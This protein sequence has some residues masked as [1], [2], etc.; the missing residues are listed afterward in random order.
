LILKNFHAPCPA[1]DTARN[2][3]S[4][5]NGGKW[6]ARRRQV[7]VLLTLSSH[8]PRRRGF[9]HKAKSAGFRRPIPLFL[10]TP[11]KKIQ[12][13]LKAL[14]GKQP[15]PEPHFVLGWKIPATMSAHVADRD[16]PPAVCV[17]KTAA[18]VLPARLFPAPCHRLPEEQRAPLAVRQHGRQ[19]PV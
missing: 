13:P 2:S 7:L 17:G 4:T 5:R 1:R 6:I 3:S 18:Q 14:G 15:E 19:L 12:R 9:V 10:R 8:P 11:E 16:H